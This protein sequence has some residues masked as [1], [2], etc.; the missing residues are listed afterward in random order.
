MEKNFD[1][2]VDFLPVSLKEMLI[3][4]RDEIKSKTY[5]VRLRTGKSITLITSDGVC[6]VDNDRLTY[7]YSD[8]IYK[9]TPTEMK[10]SFNRLCNYSVYSHADSISQ[11]F[12]TLSTGHRV[13]IGG[14]AVTEKGKI[15]SIREINS[16]NIRIAREFIGS[17]DEILKKVFHNKLKNVIIAG[18]PSSGKTT[19]LRDIARQVSSGRFG[20]YH[21]VCVIDERCEI[22]PV[23]DGNC[24][25]DVG[26]NTDVLSSFK[27]SVGI[28]TALRTLSPQLIV[29][30]EIGTTDECEAIKSGFNSGVYFVLSIHASSYDELKNKPQYKSILDSGISVSTVILSA[31]PCCIKEI[32]DTG[33][34]DAENLCSHFCGDSFDF[35]RAVCQ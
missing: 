27:K 34:E 9:V 4:V 10:E 15:T 14:T 22:S 3:K 30:D 19:L 8:D 29:C 7:I 23:K 13:G 16:L 35:D 2:A 11:G 33:E 20:E 21:K 17:A 24:T 32:M 28:M 31:K 26:V 1:R 5:E 18:P 12:I 25:C 6:F